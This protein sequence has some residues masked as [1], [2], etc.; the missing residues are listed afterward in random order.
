MQSVQQ[1]IV[2]VEWEDC[3]GRHG[4]SDHLVNISDRSE[5]SIHSLGYVE[6]DDEEGM[7]LLTGRDTAEASTEQ[8]YDCSKFIPRSAIRKVTELVR[9]R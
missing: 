9:K 7:I 2:E 1:R 3:V 6:K 5:R 8:T 4:W